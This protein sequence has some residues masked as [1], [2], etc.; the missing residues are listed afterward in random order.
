[1]V[2]HSSIPVKSIGTQIKK[3]IFKV[4]YKIIRSRRHNSD[5]RLL[6]ARGKKIFSAP[7]HWSF[8]KVTVKTTR[9]IA[10]GFAP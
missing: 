3:V 4:S 2:K 7:Q 8:L 10:K 1:M 9:R 6:G 5:L